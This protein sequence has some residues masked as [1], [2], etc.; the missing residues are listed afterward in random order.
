MDKLTFLIDR[1]LKP[2]YEKDGWLPT[3]LFLLLIVGVIAL[4]VYFGYGK[5]VLALLGLQ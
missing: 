3:F 5:Y 1:Y 4:T 2:I